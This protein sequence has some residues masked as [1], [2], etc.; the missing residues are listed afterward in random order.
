MKAVEVVT[1]N[2][3]TEDS[4]NEVVNGNQRG[5]YAKR[6]QNG[7]A[8]AT[9]KKADKRRS[10]VILGHSMVKHVYG[11]DLKE[12]CR[13]NCNVYVKSFPGA[14]A[15]DM[16]SYSQPSVERKPDIA[17]LHIGTNDLVT[18]RGEEMKSEVEIAQGIVDL[19]NHI[20]SQ[21]IEV[22]VS[23]IIARG[24]KHLDKKRE[25]VNSIRKNLRTEK[26]LTFIDHPNVKAN[27]H[28][29]RSKL[30]LNSLGDNIL[31]NNLL[32]SLRF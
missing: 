13:D 25:K 32:S 31:T 23:G 2:S 27:K 28:L 30:H 22:V 19:A 4:T 3:K 12:K 17:L 16:Y 21:D 9:A 1:S 10:G 8:A 26:K 18:R 29:K 15:K 11:W 6:L 14:T 20:R 7:E 5:F 24:E